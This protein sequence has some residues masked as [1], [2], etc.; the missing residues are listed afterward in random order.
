MQLI[1]VR[2]KDDLKEICEPPITALSGENNL[3]VLSPGHQVKSQKPLYN[4]KTRTEF[5]NS[6]LPF[7]RQLIFTA[8]AG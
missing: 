7:R 6:R 2:D 1:A 3:T 8:H 4:S 5:Q